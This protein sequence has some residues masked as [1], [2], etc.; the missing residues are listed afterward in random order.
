VTASDVQPAYAPRSA[1][2][3]DPWPV[4]AA[5]RSAC[6]VAH[7]P[8][9]GAVAVLRYEDITRTARDPATFVNRFHTARVLPD[10]LPVEA[11]VLAFADADRHGR[12]R[13]LLSAALS[14]SRVEER[15][16]RIQQ[17]AD[18]LVDAILAQG[19]S[20]ELVDH[21]ARPFPGAVL[22]EVL[23]VPVTDRPYFVRGAQLSEAGAS[24]ARREDVPWVAELDA[25]QDYIRSLVA[26]KRASGDASEDLISALCFAEVR[27]E[28]FTDEEVAQMAKLLLQAGN[29]TTTSLIGNV[30]V[31][32]DAHPDQKE[33][34]LSDLSGRVK[35][36]V[37]ET[38]RYDGPLHGLYR[39]AVEDVQIGGCPVAAGTPVWLGFGAG[40]H[41][42]EVFPDPERYDIT[43]SFS[44]PHLGFGQGMHFCAGSN[45]ARA[46]AVVAL[47]T[48]YRR[49][50]GLRVRAG[51]VPEQL[52]AAV[53]RSWQT[54]EM[55]YDAP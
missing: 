18:E 19:T 2:P 46:E 7:N 49:L 32:L 22:A 26:T 6:P 55:V 52:P 30:A 42:P 23:G 41:D 38:L 45:L 43:R 47:E 29:T 25:W 13:R 37:E 48:L 1:K 53:F 54:V 44:T 33:L 31:A 4:I 36:V 39:R 8:D 3:A 28:R 15:K 11:Q 5:D 51:F 20:F 9:L 40:S 34:F 27:G 12:Q 10:E 24:Y 14:A 50:P 35:G 16:E 17:I 21:F